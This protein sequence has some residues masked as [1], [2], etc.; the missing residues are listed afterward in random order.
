[1][2]GSGMRSCVRAG[3]TLAFVYVCVWCPL[4]C[5]LCVCLSLSVC[6]CAITMIAEVL[7]QLRAMGITDE[8]LLNEMLAD[9]MAAIPR[10]PPR[11][12]P[13]PPQAR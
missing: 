13:P 6:V 8:R 10:E 1:M 12:T 2:G 9:A 4:T 5:F 11:A 3:R 7:A